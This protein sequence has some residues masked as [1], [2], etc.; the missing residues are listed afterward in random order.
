MR[1]EL[2]GSGSGPAVPPLPPP[3]NQSSSAV[4]K[5]AAPAPDTSPA[6]AW[7]DAVAQATA[8]SPQQHVTVEPGDTL[9]GIADHNNAT[10]PGVEKAN[11]QITDPNLIYPRQTV[12]L[13]KVTPAEV[14]TGVNNTQIKPIIT[15]M[16]NAN[17]ADQGLHSPVLAHDPGA[18][19][20][21]QAQSTQSWD[22]VEQTTLKMLTDNNH[23]PYPDEAATAEVRQLNALEPGNAKFA[24]ANNAALAQATQQW[25]QMGVTKSQ[26]SPI[27]NAY[28]NAKQ[29]T[30]SA[31]QYLQNPH[32]P[33]NRAIV[34][35]LMGSEQ[36]ANA[37]LNTA[38]ER[39]LADAANGAGKDPKARS[40]AMT[41]RAA[42]IQLV[43]PQDPAF[44]TAVDNA[45]YDLQVNKPAQA[46]ANAYTKG[47][48]QAAAAALNTATQ[49][50]SNS[51]YAG[52]IIQ[53]SQG[54]IENI[55]RDLGS[56][57]SN[58]PMPIGGR[59]AV[60][61]PTPDTG[62]PKF[63]QIYADLSQSVASAGTITIDRHSG[64]HD[65]VLLSQGGKAAADIV[66]NAIAA[67][68]PRNLTQWQSAPYASAAT[69]AITNGDGAALTFATAAALKRQGNS[70]LASVVTEG[71]A[72]G[73]QALQSKTSSDV[74][75][76]A[77]TTTTLHQLRATW[78]P[79]MTE[80]QLAKATNGYLADHPDVRQQADAQ[81]ATISRDGDAIA[82]AESAWNSYRGQLNGIGGQGDLSTAAKSLTGND[83]ST[84]F[85]VSQSPR[86]NSAIAAALGPSLPSQGSGGSVVQALISSPVWSFPRSARSALNNTYKW[87]DSRNKAIAEQ[88]QSEASPRYGAGTYLALSGIGLGLT[89]LSAWSTWGRGSGASSPEQLA[90]SAY[91]AMGFGK[92]TGEV[93]SGF[94]KYDIV[95]KFL[96]NHPGFS[97]VPDK[98]GNM[99]LSLDLPNGSK[100]DLT[101]LT[102]AGWFQRL[103]SAYYGAGALAN[104][105]QAADD[106]NNGDYAGGSFDVIGGIGNALNAAKPLVPGL[107]GEVDAEGAAT[108]T[109]VAAADA[110]AALGS[111]LGLVAAAGTLIWLGIRSAINANHYQEDGSKFLQ[112]GLGLNS[113]LADW[114]ALPGQSTSASA[115]LNAYAHAY[116]LSPRQ[117][118]GL[119][120]SKLNK[121]PLDKAIEFINEAAG[122]PTQPGGGYAAS[123]PGDGPNKVGTHSVTM[124]GDKGH[125][126][127]ENVANQADSLRQLNYWADYIFG[128]N[129]L[130]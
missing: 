37:Q 47:G 17:L 60:L 56:I 15:A 92:Y 10:L 72:T 39:S 6:K 44:Q 26:L 1:M 66:G 91:T 106:F 104:F 62:D 40:A 63:N 18:V 45:N 12:Y 94:A 120:L 49:H 53:Q 86:M 55:A 21:A 36:Q 19:G 64:G 25:K 100:V 130:G 28:N 30:N 23:S 4:A 73:I 121:E 8:N 35:D 97:L 32:M 79:F 95:Q 50:T 52:Q 22:A 82:E 109:G 102:K 61:D 54:T 77:T 51:Y 81:L 33:H 83:A 127:T 122:M 112:R 84:A 24:A 119:L 29:T 117:Q 80:N 89:G 98:N 124:L 68:A 110:V 14:V 42:N 114:L 27:I 16:A 90:T 69:N 85:A 65:S 9:T 31:N 128:K 87:L 93:V 58:E 2:P 123:M 115:A 34:D 20:E 101:N 48:A 43:G 105:L 107:M 113:N 76:F 118:P 108:A 111:G 71:A 88:T 75:A 13:P 129:Q 11:P 46:V 126:W 103:G 7:I 70:D 78:G 74:T 57:A 116:G 96:G 67:N 3:Q 5:P 41:D 99:A 59:A 38:I 125:N